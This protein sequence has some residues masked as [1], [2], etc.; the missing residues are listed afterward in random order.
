MASIHRTNARIRRIQKE[1][2]KKLAAFKRT[3]AIEKAALKGECLYGHKLTPDN[4]TASG[5]CRKCHNDAQ[6]KSHERKPKV[7]Q[8]ISAEPLAGL[9]YRQLSLFDEGLRGLSI[10]LAAN[11]GTEDW[12]TVE[13][14]LGE[15][16]RNPSGNVLRATADRI[17]IGLNSHPSIIYDPSVWEA[18]P[19]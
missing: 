18:M 14:Q 7:S 19:A 2:A 5:R 17:I 6:K 15:I 16:Y 13:S 11:L 4:L 1:R 8:L 10:H 9:I 12:E 3:L